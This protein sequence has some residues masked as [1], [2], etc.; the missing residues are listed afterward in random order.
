MAAGPGASVGF[1][2]ID[3]YFFGMRGV[4]L[5]I[6]PPKTMK[7]WI[8]CQGVLA[9]AREGRQPWLFS[10]ELPAEEA[11]M[12]LRCL[13]ADVPWWHYIRNCIE[14]GEWQMIH[15]ATEELNAQGGYKI[16]KPRGWAPGHRGDG[17][18]RP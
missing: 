16:V 5:W 9:N 3:D 1:P 4:T 12:R 8:M 10:L 11:D 6:A 7:S 15:A 2:D 13:M 14:P 18:G 17:A